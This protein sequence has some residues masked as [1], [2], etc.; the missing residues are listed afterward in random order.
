MAGLAGDGLSAQY[1]LQLA[2]SDNQAS[3]WIS[4]H[5]GDELDAVLG[6]VQAAWVWLRRNDNF[7]MP[8]SVDSLEGWI[9]DPALQV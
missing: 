8:R 7:G 1:G 6:A 3:D 4:D 5:S 2:F 9:C